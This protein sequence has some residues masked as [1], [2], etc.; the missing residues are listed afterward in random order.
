MRVRV[1]ARVRGEGEG[2]GEGER[3]VPSRGGLDELRMRLD[4]RDDRVA[5]LGEREEV[6][7][8]GHP[9]HRRARR[10]ES[11][12]ELVLR[13]E[14][15]V[16]DRVPALVRAWVRV[17]V[18]VRVGVG[19]GVRVSNQ[20]LSLT[21]RAEVDVARREELAPPAVPHAYGTAEAGTRTLPSTYSTWGPGGKP[22]CAS[23]T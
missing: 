3:L 16:S 14:G 1:R 4:V 2:E 21:T 13:V 11:V 15:L 10:R 23:G 6:R 12:D 19:V 22:P 8:L 9:L 5:E 7:R 20:T 18:G 17:R